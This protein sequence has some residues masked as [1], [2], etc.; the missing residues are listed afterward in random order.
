MELAAKEFL[1]RWV[2]SQ[3]VGR[4]AAFYQLPE[5]AHIE[6][7]KARLREQGVLYLHVWRAED[8]RQDMLPWKSQWVYRVKSF[9]WRYQLYITRMSFSEVDFAQWPA[10][11]QAVW[12]EVMVDVPEEIIQV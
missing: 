6:H 12:H 10:D 11:L 9:V 8:T 3:Y 4:S 2:P 1:I 5:P 7:M